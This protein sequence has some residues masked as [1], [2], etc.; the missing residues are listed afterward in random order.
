MKKYFIS[1]ILVMTG[2]SALAQTD[3]LIIKKT[4]G[5]TIKYNVEDISRMWF[6]YEDNMFGKPADI[7]DLGLSVKWA[8]WN[9]GASKPEEYGTYFYWG[10]PTGEATK[11]D[12]SNNN[13]SATQYDAAHVHWG[14][15]WRLPTHAEMEELVSNCTFKWTTRN[16]VAGGLFTS[17]KNGYTNKS[18]FIPAAGDITSSGTRY[19]GEQGKCWCDEYFENEGNYGY[20][21]YFDNSSCYSGHGWGVGIKIPIRP[22][23]G[24]KGNAP[25]ATFTVTTG[26]AT[27]ITES[28]VTLKGSVSAQNVSTQYTYGIYVSKTGTPSSSNFIQN[29]YRNSSSSYQTMECSFNGLTAN[30]TYYYRAYVI[31]GNNMYYGDTKSF[32]TSSKQPS[33]SVTT[34]DASEITENSAKLTCTIVAKNTSGTMELGMFIAES[35]TPS[36]TNGNRMSG[37]FTGDDT[38]DLYGTADE[39]DAN[40]TYKFRAYAYYDGKY[41]YGDTKSFTTKQK[42]NPTTGTLNGHEWVDLGLPSGLKWATCNVGANSSTSYGDYYAWGETSTKNYYSDDNYPNGRNS[43][44]PY[45]ISGTSYDVAH[46]KWGSSWRMPTFGEITELTRN[47]TF[48][49]T[50]MNNVRGA[51]ITGPNGNYIFLPAGGAIGKGYPNGASSYSYRGENGY[52]WSATLYYRQNWNEVKFM[53][54]KSSGVSL[55]E[56]SFGQYVDMNTNGFNGMLIRPVTN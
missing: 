12:L 38:Y 31:Y 46:V 16:G 19:V 21:I 50:T 14:G 44:I 3:Y 43:S 1:L 29:E 20:T 5:N 17:K 54:F 4:D 25:Q 55:T 15:D 27:N 9:V 47:C 6:E 41:Y 33:F 11:A 28:T 49:W 10:D 40:T 7:V 42:A 2:I 56:L 51:K 32:T 26:T 48:T 13:I 39:L 37:N 30:T 52:Y 45:N 35:G 24:K 36:S 18:I 22:V 34:G 8:S 53:F 23:Y